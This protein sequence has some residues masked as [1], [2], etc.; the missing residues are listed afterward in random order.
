MVAASGLKIDASKK[1]ISLNPYKTDITVP[2]FTGEHIGTAV[3]SG[4][5][6]E[7]TL[8]EGSLDGWMIAVGDKIQ[9]VKIKE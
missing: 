1:I 5:S 7:I 4:D 2:F 3:F 6:C 8:K 9:S